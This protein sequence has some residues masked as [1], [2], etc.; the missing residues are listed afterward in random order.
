MKEKFYKNREKKRE[1]EPLNKS[2]FFSFLFINFLIKSCL[3][4]Y[5]T[6]KIV[7]QL[8]LQKATVIISKLDSNNLTAFYVR[9]CTNGLVYERIQICIKCTKTK[10]L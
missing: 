5:V 8:H 1:K 6:T 9:V 2:V 10:V 3:I 4:L 7:I